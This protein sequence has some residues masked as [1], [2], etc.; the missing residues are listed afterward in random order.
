MPKVR[1]FGYFDKPGTWVKVL[2]LRTGD[3][4]DTDAGVRTVK[5][6]DPSGSECL[7]QFQEGGW[8]SEQ[9]ETAIQLE[10]SK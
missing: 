3:K 8:T 7:I 6:V 5:N 1:E 9:P 10:A 4:V 2:D